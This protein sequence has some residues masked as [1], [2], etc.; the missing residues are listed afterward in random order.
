MHLF[1]SN[2][3]NSYRPSDSLPGTL[4]IDQLQ[5]YQLLND[6]APVKFVHVLPYPACPPSVLM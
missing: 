2:F 4:F 6:Q 5:T 1:G 3:C